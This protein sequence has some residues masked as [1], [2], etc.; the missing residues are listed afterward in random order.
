MELILKVFRVLPTEMK[1]TSTDTECRRRKRQ[2]AFASPSWINQIYNGWVNLCL[3]ICVQIAWV[4]CIFSFAGLRHA[5]SIYCAAFTLLICFC[6]D[7]ID[8]ID[9]ISVRWSLWMANQSNRIFA[10]WHY[11]RSTKLQCNV[12]RVYCSRYGCS[13]RGPRIAERHNHYRGFPTVIDDAIS[14]FM[15]SRS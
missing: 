2:N 10:D 15:T 11:F 5:E 9:W 3:A 13:K 4:C 8:S 7:F 12:S 6:S 14:P 1:C